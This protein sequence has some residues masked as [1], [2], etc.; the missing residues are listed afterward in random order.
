[1]VEET[2]MRDHYRC[3]TDPA[4]ALAGR[5]A[6]L[7]RH[8]HLD[9]QSEGFV[10][11]AACVRFPQDHTRMVQASWPQVLLCLGSRVD[12]ERHGPLP[13]DCVDAEGLP[14][15]EAR[16]AWLV[17][18]RHDKDRRGQ[19]PCWVYRQVLQQGRSA[20]FVPQRLE[21]AR[22]WWFGCYQQN[23]NAMVVVPGVG[24][25]MV[26]K[27]HRRSED[28]GRWFRLRRYRRVEIFSLGCIFR[29]Y[30]CF[31]CHCKALPLVPPQ[32]TETSETRA[33][34]S[35]LTASQAENGDH[36]PT[37]AFRTRNPR[38]ALR[39]ITKEPCREHLVGPRCSS[40]GV[41]I[42]RCLHSVYTPDQT[43]SI[44]I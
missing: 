31:S 41:P 15:T 43:G 11:L 20:E 13:C 17:A 22:T 33:R 7:S 4:A 36:A 34:Q 6:N 10:E 9:V 25:E 23:R 35:P 26:F 1:L 12:E 21:S 14:P 32:Y 37:H 44:T 40:R 3:K 38:S 39:G 28:D 8:D 29:G 42:L 24:S 18:S 2:T 27:H 19:E 5:R 16:Q 30:F